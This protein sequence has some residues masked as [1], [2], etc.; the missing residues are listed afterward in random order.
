MVLRLGSRSYATDFTSACL[1][2]IWLLPDLST[3]LLVASLSSSD[4]SDMACACKKEIKQ[5]QQTIVRSC[6]FLIAFIDYD[7]KNGNEKRQASCYTCPVIYKKY[8]KIRY[9][10]HGYSNT[11]C[12]MYQRNEMRNNYKLGQSVCHR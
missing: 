2:C 6:F 10:I 4:W 9:G 1:A 12:K 8:R 7:L 5:M 11:A 3:S